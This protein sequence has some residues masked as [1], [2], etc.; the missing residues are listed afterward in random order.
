[1]PMGIPCRMTKP[2][3][4]VGIRSTITIRR[5]KNT[6]R[7]PLF[8]VLIPFRQ[9]SHFG[10]LLVGQDSIIITFTPTVEATPLGMWCSL[11]HKEHMPQVSLRRLQCIL[12]RGIVLYLSLIVLLVVETRVEAFI[13][14]ILPRGQKC[15]GNLLLQCSPCLS[16]CTDSLKLSTCVA[17]QAA[18]S[19]NLCHSTRQLVPSVRATNI[20]L[21]DVINAI[22]AHSQSRR[23]I[24]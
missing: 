16:A 8:M 13:L 10:N 3:L 12:E 7:L 2:T 1:M 23:A 14:L 5:R 6:L 19:N 11:T 24:T 20:G 21:V 22:Q 4:I 18:A 15:I 9:V 17:S